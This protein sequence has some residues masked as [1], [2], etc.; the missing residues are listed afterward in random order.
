LCRVM[1]LCLHHQ[2]DRLKK[3][4]FRSAEHGEQNRPLPKST[5][6]MD[7]LKE[8]IFTVWFIPFSAFSHQV[9]KVN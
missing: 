1:R 2:F 7:I 3:R 5:T 9:M 6:R 8:P 4:P